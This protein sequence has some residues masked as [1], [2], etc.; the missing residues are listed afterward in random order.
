MTEENEFYCIIVNWSLI[1]V[2]FF[3]RLLDSMK[4]PGQARSS[5]FHICDILDLN[6]AKVHGDPSGNISASTPISGKILILTL[7]S[8]VFLNF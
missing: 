7:L 5:G 2:F 1:L 6:D 8:I 3:D 4:M